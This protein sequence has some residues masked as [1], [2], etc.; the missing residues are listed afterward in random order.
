MCLCAEFTY[1]EGRWFRHRYLSERS[2]LLLTAITKFWQ[3]QTSKKTNKQK[4]SREIC[5]KF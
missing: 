3:K 4:K 1:K 5:Q 2:Y